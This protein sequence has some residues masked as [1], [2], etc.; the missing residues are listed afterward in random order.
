MAG[1]KRS[2]GKRQPR[3][4]GNGAPGRSTQGAASHRAGADPKQAMAH[5]GTGFDDKLQPTYPL[6]LSKVQS[7]SD[8]VEAYSRTA[9]G[10]RAVGEAA[11]ILLHMT[12]DR[13][14]FVVATVTGAMRS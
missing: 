13:D 3:A 10:A 2:G 14:C 6:D 5:Y 4:G 7:V 11:D 9:I 8:L 1:K 12:R